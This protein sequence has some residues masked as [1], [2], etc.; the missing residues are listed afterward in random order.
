MKPTTTTN[1]WF[2][3]EPYV[4]ISVTNENALLYN[5][6]DRSSIESNR[7]EIIELL[8]EILQEENCGVVLLNNKRYKG[9]TVNSF[10]LELKKKYMGDIIDTSLSKE[11][12][13]QLLPFFNFPN[14]HEIYKKHNFSPLKNILDNLSEITINI[15]KTINTTGLA[16]FIQSIPEKLTFNI[17][18]NIIN[19]TPYKNIL[20]LLDELNAPKNIIYSYINTIE[21]SQY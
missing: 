16:S 6:L 14:K 2:F 15:D 20:S 4:Y 21:I 19:I 13:I 1:Y 9:E 5:T 7:I 18:L 17:I 10:I 12:P 8:R 3:I 11:K